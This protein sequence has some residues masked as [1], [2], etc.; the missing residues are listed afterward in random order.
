MRFPVANN[1]Y[2]KNDPIFFRSSMHILPYLVTRVTIYGDLMES[3][4]MIPNR[5]VFNAVFD[6]ESRRVAAADGPKNEKTCCV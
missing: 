4:L 6:G 5:L 1:P 3:D 2:T